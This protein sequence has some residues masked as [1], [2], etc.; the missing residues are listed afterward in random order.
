MPEPSL[1]VLLNECFYLS[2]YEPEQALA[3]LSQAEQLTNAKLN[4]PQVTFRSLKI[5][6]LLRASHSPSFRSPPALLV[7][8]KWKQKTKHKTHAQLGHKKPQ[9]VKSARNSKL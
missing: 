7:R 3:R 1:R 4:Q 8:L 9:K 2:H 6:L 5:G